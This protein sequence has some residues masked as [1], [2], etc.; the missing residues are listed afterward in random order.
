M[1]LLAGKNSVKMNV[2]QRL[3]LDDFRSWSGNVNA[4]NTMKRTMAKDGLLRVTMPHYVKR[5]S[6]YDVINKAVKK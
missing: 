6:V 2:I 1:E 4:R 5:D 3:H